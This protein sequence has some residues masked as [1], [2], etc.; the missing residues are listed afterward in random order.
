MPIESFDVVQS[1]IKCF[2]VIVSHMKIHLV[3]VS[4]MNDEALVILV[5]KLHVSRNKVHAVALDG[6]PAVLGHEDGLVVGVSEHV[7]TIVL[8]EMNMIDQSEERIENIDQSEV[9]IENIDQS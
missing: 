9:R 1:L 6:G 2:S 4:V 7:V 8:G 5:I 3:S